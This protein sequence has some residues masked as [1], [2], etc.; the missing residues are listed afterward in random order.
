MPL[1]CGIVGLPNVGKSSLFSALTSI[2]APIENYPFCTIDPNVGLVEMPDER[3]A[4]LRSIYKPQKTIATTCEFVDI[5]GL[6]KGASKGEG[7]GNKFLANIR[8]TGIVAHV[9]RCFDDTTITHVSGTI[10][11]LDDIVTIN[12]ELALADL[13]TVQ[14]QKDRIVKE[15]KIKNAEVQKKIAIMHPLLDKLEDALNNSKPL[16]TLE[17]SDDEQTA[18]RQL[19]LLR[20]KPMM[21]VCNVPE[22]EVQTGNQYTA[23]VQEYAKEEQSSVLYISAKF[24]AELAQFSSE[25]KDEF[26]QSVG[27]QQSSLGL[28]IK[29]AYTM[30]G[31][32][33]FF[34][35]G[36]KE[37]HAW[38][39]KD[40][41]VAPEAA[42]IIHSDFQKGFI[43][44]EVFSYDDLLVC[45]S[46][47][48]IRNSGKLRTEGKEYRVQDGDIMHFRFNV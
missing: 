29:T 13:E 24:E 48:N 37:V 25:E 20:M 23:I 22:D 11:P 44:A 32:R 36:E 19:Q 8:E 41:M 35:A 15:K 27:I 46:E 16:Y 4:K 5:A 7:L 3:V 47:A 10:N 34:T 9:L 43:R 28:L 26:L 1:N 17:Y 39:F 12:T 40:G 2:A 31:L 6:V 21:Y 33:T 30:L 45:G 18:L 42:G 38:T 14:K